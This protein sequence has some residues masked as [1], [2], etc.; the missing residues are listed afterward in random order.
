M[1]PF[2]LGIMLGGAIGYYLIG[3][4]EEHGKKH[5]V[6]FDYET[7]GKGYDDG[8]EDGYK[9]GYAEC[10]EDEKHRKSQKEGI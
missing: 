7:Y 10:L 9:K 4:F 3:Y 5:T 1:I 8:F 6:I 2:L